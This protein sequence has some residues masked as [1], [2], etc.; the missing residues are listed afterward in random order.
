MAAISWSS[1]HTGIQR[2]TTNLRPPPDWDANSRSKNHDHSQRLVVCQIAN[3]ALHEAGSDS[4]IYLVPDLDPSREEEHFYIGQ[5]DDA[6]ADD[7]DAGSMRGKKRQRNG[8]E[9]VGET[10]TGNR[11]TSSATISN[12]S[13]RM[14][15][16]SQGSSGFDTVI[17]FDT[18]MSSD[19]ETT[20]ATGDDSSETTAPE[21]ETTAPEKETTA[22]EKE[23]EKETTVTTAPETTTPE[24][25]TTPDR[26]YPFRERKKPPLYPP[27]AQSEETEKNTQN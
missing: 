4:E 20:T 14:M 2:A 27:S 19:T 9:K 26:R 18:A 1:V 15:R 23:K 17:G 24:N 7:S 21:K 13:R 25:E 10:S 5:I 12:R 6:D 22:P 3:R 11:R 8:K 16:T